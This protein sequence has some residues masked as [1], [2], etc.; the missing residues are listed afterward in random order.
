MDLNKDFN[1]LR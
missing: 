1:R